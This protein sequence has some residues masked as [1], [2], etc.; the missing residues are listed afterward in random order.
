MLGCLCSEGSTRPRGPCQWPFAEST[1]V[2]AQDRPDQTI[3]GELM[4]QAQLVDD[5]T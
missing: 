2:R 3:R 5:S 4:K 1:G